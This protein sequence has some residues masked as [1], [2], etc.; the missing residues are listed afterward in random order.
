MVGLHQVFDAHVQFG[1]RQRLGQK[2]TR[3]GRERLQLSFLISTGREQYNRDALSRGAL[4]QFLAGLQTV[5]F[6][7]HHIQQ[8]DIGQK[9]AGFLNGLLPIDGFEDLIV[10]NELRFEKTQHVLL[11]VR[12]QH[13]GLIAV[14]DALHRTEGFLN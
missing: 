9:L 14:A 8:N 4:A 10:S 1:R 11:V 2:V 6:R 3:A 7:H 5:L 13:L 12:Y